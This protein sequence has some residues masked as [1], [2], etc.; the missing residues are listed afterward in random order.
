MQANIEVVEVATKWVSD[1][2]KAAKLAKDWTKTYPK[3]T[4]SGPMVI[5]TEEAHG[6]RI[7]FFK[8]VEKSIPLP[9]RE[10]FLVD[11]DA[12]CVRGPFTL[13]DAKHHKSAVEQIVKRKS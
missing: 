13:K 5:V 1:V 9:I 10:H 3:Y 12:A 4:G 6:V 2:K 7:K 11:F 8:P